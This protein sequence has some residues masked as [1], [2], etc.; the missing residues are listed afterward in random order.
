[1][2][3]RA[4]PRA[5]HDQAESDARGASE[6]SPATEMHLADT[7]TGQ[8]SAIRRAVR[9]F[10]SWLATGRRQLRE[11]RARRVQQKNLVERLADR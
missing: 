11:A 1:M 4:T 8:A 7:S 9:V 2:G 5:V 3:A 6:A 10:C